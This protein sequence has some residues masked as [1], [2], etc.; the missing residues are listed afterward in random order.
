MSS[1]SVLKR[2][3]DARDERRASEPM[4]FA[5]VA[6]VAPGIARRVW[7]YGFNGLTYDETF[8]ARARACPPTADGSTKPW[9][10]GVTHVVC[11]EGDDG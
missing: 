3:V 7:R 2:S 11:L 4:R 1:P 6:I 5:R 10:G 8:T 9:T